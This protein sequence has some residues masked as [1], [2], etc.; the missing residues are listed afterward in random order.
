MVGVCSRLPSRKRHDPLGLRRG[1]CGAAPTQAPLGQ[2]RLGEGI[3]GKCRAQSAQRHRTF[4]EGPSTK[5]THTISLQG[6]LPP[7]LRED[8]LAYTLVYSKYYSPHYPTSTVILK[9]IFSLTR[10]CFLASIYDFCPRH[11]SPG[12]RF[13]GPV[14]LRLC[15]LASLG[16][17]SM[18]LQHSDFHAAFED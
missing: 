4:S 5:A 10:S 6:V 3:H 13:L 1:R 17:P 15:S 2:A 11:C 18:E 16:Y 7:S 14:R 9:F 8:H 12:F